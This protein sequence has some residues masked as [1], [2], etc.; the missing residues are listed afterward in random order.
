MLIRPTDAEVD[1]Y[2]NPVRDVLH[3]RPG[4][5]STSMKV[6]L[7][8]A[9]GTK[10]LEENVTGSAFEPA[11]IDVRGLAPGTYSISVECGGREQTG[12][13]VKI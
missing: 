4:I 10:V 11:D 13:V 8:S 1:W 12:V 5:A 7:F 9:T 3:V 6:R 2:P